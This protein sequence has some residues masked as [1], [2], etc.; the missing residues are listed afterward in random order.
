MNTD[1]NGQ[2]PITDDAELAKVLDDMNGATNSTQA[3][4]G[5]QFEEA[6]LPPA[7]PAP[8]NDDL[9]PLSPPPLPEAAVVEEPVVTPE[10]SIYSPDPVVSP[11]SLDDVKKDALEQLRPLVD[12][13]NLPA[14]EKFDTLLLIIR[15]TDD[16][17]LVQAAYDTAKTIDD[18]TRRAQALLD[19]IKEIDYFSAQAK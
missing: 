4:S 15:S 19:V 10:V 6:P 8:A 12:K 16:Q 17:S 14:E 5:L 1:D 11:S 13:L 7:D 18:E 2:Q 9:T 3:T